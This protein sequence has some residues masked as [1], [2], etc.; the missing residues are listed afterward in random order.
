[1]VSIIFLTVPISTSLEGVWAGR[2]GSAFLLAGPFPQASHSTHLTLWGLSL[3]SEYV[4]FRNH[5][6]SKH[7]LAP[8]SD[9]QLTQEQTILMLKN[10]LTY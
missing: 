9:T 5:I 1:M 7:K 6:V 3:E 2:L 10:G 8:S 4:L